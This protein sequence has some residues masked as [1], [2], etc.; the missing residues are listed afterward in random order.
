VKITTTTG[1]VGFLIALSA[2]NLSK[3]EATINQPTT[4]PAQSTIEQRLS[5]ISALIK[6]QENQMQDSSDAIDRA[7]MIAGFANRGGGGGFAN[8]GGGGGFVNRGGGG[9]FVN[10]GGGGGFVNVNPW[11]NGW[12]DGGGFFNSRW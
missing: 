9:G 3:A 7:L 4:Q 11:R 5:R 12:A 2:L 6:E 1:L 10:R 8:R